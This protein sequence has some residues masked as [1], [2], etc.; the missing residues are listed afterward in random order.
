MSGNFRRKSYA[1]LEPD[2][3]LYGIPVSGVNDALH[4]Q[5]KFLSILQASSSSS[6]C[7]LNRLNAD[8]H[9]CQSLCTVS[10][11]LAAP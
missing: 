1:H 10:H 7:D 8:E 6:R 2:A 11:P 3:S 5:Q 4:Y 9:L